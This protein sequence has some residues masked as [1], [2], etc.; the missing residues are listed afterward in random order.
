MK[1]TI[2]NA[3]GHPAAR[4]KRLLREL[5]REGVDALLVTDVNNVRY[6]SGFTGDDSALLVSADESVLITDSRYS[7]QAESEAPSI[8][9]F[10]R[11]VGLMQAA[12]QLAHRKGVGNLAVESHNMS[13]AAY[14]VLKTA[15]GPLEIT[16][17]NGLV[18]KLRAFKD[19]SEIRHIRRA[20]AIASEA[21]IAIMPKLRPGMT[22]I[23][24]GRLL[25]RTMEDMG[26]AGPAFP[27]VVAAGERSSLPHAQPTDRR[28][29]HGEAVLFDWG[30]QF[31]L[32]RS[33]LT[34]VVFLYRI[35]KL[36]RRLY[37]VVLEAQKRALARIKPGISAK[38]VDAAARDYL[39]SRRH[40]KHFGHGLGHGVGLEIHEAPSL[41]YM[42]DVELK[43]GMVVTVEPGVY[44]PGQ[45]GVRIEDLV[46]IKP[47]GHE[48]LT[49][50]PK[51]M[52]DMIVSM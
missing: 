14:N 11:Q 39:K 10:V 6:L 41:S 3:A 36:F 42:A 29:K 2:D 43:S 17:I 7:E 15:C 8:K 40:G 21:F 20:A 22:E 52:E 12:G 24:A 48:C 4:R 26:A 32:Y 5:A 34:R 19:S 18:K 37:P 9:I 30:A 13:L 16:Q 25:D 44:L 50:V 23:E 35:P 45:G 51:S 33:D 46:L 31:G 28:I 47:K 38:A 27:T 49:A 1:R